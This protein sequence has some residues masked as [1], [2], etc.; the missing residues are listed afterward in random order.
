MFLEWACPV[1]DFFL[2]LPGNTESNI[3]NG[4]ILDPPG[5]GNTPS[6]SY[7]A[8]EE[9]LKVVHRTILLDT[10]VAFRVEKC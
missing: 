7:T 2:S 3:V 9:L 6:N 5:A 10:I 1:K 4:Y 8:R